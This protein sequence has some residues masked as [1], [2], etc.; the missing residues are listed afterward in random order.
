[1]WGNRPYDTG[2]NPRENNLVTYGSYGEGYHNYHHTFPWDYAASELAWMHTF[3]FTTMFI[4]F[5]SALG[6]AYDRKRVS[7]ET[8]QQRQERTGVTDDDDHHHHLTTMMDGENSGQ[9]DRL[10]WRRWFI[11]WSL[12]LSHLWIPFLLRFFL[13]IS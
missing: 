13:L 2:I 4:D 10:L 1:M 3:N 12:A 8:L 9:H 5:F 6:W 7:R 11:I